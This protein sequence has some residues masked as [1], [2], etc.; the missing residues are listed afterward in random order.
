[1]LS[2]C[3]RTNDALVREETPASRT[4]PSGPTVELGKTPPTG[5][6]VAVVELFT[7]EG[8]SSCPAADAT[9]ARIAANA[10][11]SGAPIFTVELH[12]DYWDY[13]GWRDPFDDAR[14][15]QRQAGYRALTGSTYTPQAVVNGVKETVGSDT[16]R[17]NDL[18]ALALAAP[19][20]TR[21]AV[22][23]KW[24]DGSVVVHC[25]G[26]GAE[27]AQT[28]NLFVLEEGAESS[29]TRGENAGERLRHR[30]VA[31]AFDA[32]VVS[33]G[34]FEATWQAP[35]PRNLSRADVRVL[36]FT[37]RQHQA[38]ITGATVALPK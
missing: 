34:H 9:L 12:V 27:S 25:Q 6:G 20:T 36:A 24:Q 11:R 13:L 15:S 16:S 31:R 38:G 14:F 33:A 21:L 32:Q 23:A 29:V 35:V 8:C 17:L 37:E 1:L 5:P 18:I 7:S 22:S 3:S 30:N 4:E 28:L 10:E 2:G 19:A 26:D